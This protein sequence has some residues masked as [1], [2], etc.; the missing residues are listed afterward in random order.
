MDQCPPKILAIM[1]IFLDNGST[2]IHML[3]VTIVKL[4]VLARYL[5]VHK[6]T[7]YLIMVKYTLV[8]H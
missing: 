3:L 1:I 8:K 7:R 5:N 4:I 2:A 6:G